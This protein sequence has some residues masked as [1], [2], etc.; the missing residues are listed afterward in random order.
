MPDADAAI[1]TLRRELTLRS[2]LT[3]VGVGA[4]TG[5]LAAWAYYDDFFRPLAHSFGIW[6]FA[7]ALLSMRRSLPTAVLRSVL[8]LGAAVVIF[9]V[10]KK[11]MYALHYPGMSYAVNPSDLVEWLVLAVVAGSLLGCAFHRIG[12]RGR[13]GS[14]STAAAVGLLVADAYRRAGNHPADAAALLLVAVPAVLVLLLLTYRSPRQL[15]TTAL[16]VG[17]MACLGWVLV[18]LP[19]ALEQAFL[20]GG[21]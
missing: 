6:V 3:A 19:D 16:L 14:M 20:T 15:G 10:G 8:S 11:V 9:F 5:A 4:L 2:A 1:P 17:P 21:F 7:T 13:A 18:S 12:S